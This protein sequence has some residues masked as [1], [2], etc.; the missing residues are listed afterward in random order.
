[1]TKTFLYAALSDTTGFWK[2]D[3]DYRFPGVLG[4]TARKRKIGLSP[5]TWAMKSRALYTAFT[6][7]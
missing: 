5:I 7:A 1:M 6:R 2:L 3:P 4:G